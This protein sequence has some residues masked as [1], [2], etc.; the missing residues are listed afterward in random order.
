LWSS[1]FRRFQEEVTK[2]KIAFQWSL[3]GEKLYMHCLTK[4]KV[5]SQQYLHMFMFACKLTIVWNSCGFCSH[6]T[7]TLLHAHACIKPVQCDN[8]TLPYTILMLTT[9]SNCETIILCMEM[10]FFSFFVEIYLR[11]QKFVMK[12]HVAV[13]WYNFHSCL[14]QLWHFI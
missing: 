5:K 7:L 3:H 1:N 6:N 4:L 14:I 10:T 13:K 12:M 2:K 11:L 9:Y 8:K